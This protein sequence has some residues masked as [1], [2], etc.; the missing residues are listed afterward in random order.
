MRFAGVKFP[1]RAGT[2]NRLERIAQ[3]LLDVTQ[4]AMSFGICGIEPGSSF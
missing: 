2:A 1:P 4:Q 3:L